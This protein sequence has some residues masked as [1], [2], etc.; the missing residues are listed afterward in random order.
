MQSAAPLLAVAGILCLMPL[1]L[2]F[3]WLAA[4]NRRDRPTIVDGVW[5][6]VGLLG[7]LSGFFVVVGFVLV[8]WGTHANLLAR[9]GLRELQNAWAAG[10]LTTI[11]MPTAY[12]LL[13]AAAIAS[14][15]KGRQNSLHI[16]NVDEKHL[17][18]AITHLLQNLG[19]D[20]E[21]YGRQWSLG[22]PILEVRPFAVFSHVT[23]TLLASDA[24]LRDEIERGL[25]QAVE[26]LP[27]GENVGGQWLITAAISSF[28]TTVCCVI[29]SFVASYVNR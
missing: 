4:V 7:G 23:V 10:Q 1:T 12:V 2:Y 15:L 8:A 19:L 29:L 26:R 11:L 24:R 18:R 28:I 13:L 16:Y 14:T 27:A 20:A 17:E 21:R 5:D 22:A 9:H 6:F 25:R 3:F